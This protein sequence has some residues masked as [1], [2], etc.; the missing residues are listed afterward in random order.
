MKFSLATKIFLG[1]TLVIAVFGVVSVY[2]ITQFNAVRGQLDAVNKGFLPLNRVVAEMETL[3]ESSRRSMDNI[4]RFENL[5]RQKTLLQNSR[6]SF[7]RNMRSRL[8]QAQ[9]II[10]RIDTSAMSEKDRKFL[11]DFDSRLD[12]IRERTQEF[13]RTLETVVVAIDVEADFAAPPEEIRVFK[14][15]R[16]QLTNDVRYIALFLKNR[17]T[18]RMLNIQRDESRATGVI[19]WLSIVAVCV[20]VV[21]TFLSLLTLR[22]IR[23]LAAGAQRISKGDFSPVA[24]ISAKDEFGFLAGEFNRMAKSLA[25][26]EEEQARHQE[27][28]ERVNRDLR[29]SSIDLELMKLYNESIIRSVHNAIV[30]T[31]VHGIITTLNPP[32]EKLWE[33]QPDTTIGRKLSELPIAQALSKLTDSWEKVLLDKERLLFESVEFANPTRSEHQLVLVDLY[34]SPLVGKDGT[35]QGVLLVGED[36]TE[37]V[38]TK[39]ALLQSERLATIGRMSA[40]VAHEIRNP[41]SSIGLNAELLEDE[42]STNSKEPLKILHSIAREVEH[43]TEI[44]D[45]YLKFARLPKPTLATENLNELLSSLLNFVKGEFRG[46]SV[47]VKHQPDPEVALVRADEGQLRQAFLNL[48]R[49]S[50]ESMPEGGTLT[51]STERSD[52]LVRVRIADTGEGIDNACLDRIF[53]PFFSTREGG[54][55]LGLSLTQQIVAEHGGNIACESSPGQGTCFVVE[56]PSIKASED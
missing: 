30:V 56:L 12:R 2:G 31:D 39:Q 7:S 49:N 3:Q 21:V 13:D 22:P 5:R 26:R 15:A 51:I 53:D 8:Q 37:K 41:L 23:R 6:R 10:Q 35:T 9:T 43:L 29:Q 28:L 1:F 48:L 24:D 47:E 50:I 11:S 27:Q 34:V 46:A 38:R 54:T 33:L 20:G 36:V 55:G 17:I 52:G 45:G 14:R 4:L 19:L 42:L 16:R 32:A 18:T 44:T 40:L 25:G